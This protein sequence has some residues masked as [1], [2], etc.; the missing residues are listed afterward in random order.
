VTGKFVA[1][2]KA[3]ATRPSTRPRSDT[4]KVDL[5]ALQEERAL[6]RQTEER[7]NTLLEIINKRET[8]EAKAAEPATPAI[9][10][11]TLDPLAYIDWL[12]GRRRQDRRRDPGPNRSPSSR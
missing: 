6:R 11:K 9:P 7:M 2:D 10:D 3:D 4:R 1:K 5:R 12:E 8:S